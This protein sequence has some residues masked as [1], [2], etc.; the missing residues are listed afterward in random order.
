MVQVVSGHRDRRCVRRGGLPRRGPP[1]FAALEAVTVASTISFPETPLQLISAAPQLREMVGPGVAVDSSV[2][3]VEWSQLAVYSGSTSTNTTESR[4]VMPSCLPNLEHACL[5]PVRNE[6]EFA[7]ADSL[8][9][10]ALESLTASAASG[11]H[12]LEHLVTPALESITL[13][14]WNTEN[15]AVRLTPFLCGSKSLRRMKL[16]GSRYHGGPDVSLQPLGQLLD[17]TPGIQ[18]LTIHGVREKVLGSFCDALA[19]GRLPRLS[20]LTIINALQSA[21]WFFTDI[22][23]AV[24]AGLSKRKD[25]APPL[26][27]LHS[28]KIHVSPLANTFWGAKEPGAQGESV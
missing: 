2:F 21:T 12:I 28:L 17:L 4:L 22:V 8:T 25:L 13:S 6:P 24:A 16:Y 11:D 10:H 3:A 7:T 20:E 14:G 26:A 19:K 1:R 18:E 23:A 5:D 27:P 9:H 15:C